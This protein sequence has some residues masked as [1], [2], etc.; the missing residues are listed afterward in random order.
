M[1]LSSTL[2]VLIPL[3]SLAGLF[4][5]ASVEKNVPQGYTSTASFHTSVYIL[6][7]WTWMDIKLF[8]HN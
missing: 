1:F 6:H 5:P 7:L 2:T 3:V 4:Y 8:R